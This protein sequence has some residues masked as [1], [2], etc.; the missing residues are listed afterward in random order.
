MS[1]TTAAAEQDKFAPRVGRLVFMLHAI[2][3]SAQLQNALRDLA[4]V[5][6]M[7][8]VRVRVRTTE[9]VSGFTN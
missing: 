4:R 6:I 7:V 3:E 2:C 8:R 9:D 1:V 5:S